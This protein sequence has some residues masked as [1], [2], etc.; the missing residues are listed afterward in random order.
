MTDPTPADDAFLAILRARLGDA[1]VLT[2][3]ADMAP[4]L[5]EARGLYRGSARAVVRPADAGEVA[6]AVRVCAEA[7]VPIVPQGGNTGLVGG[8]VPHGGIVLSLA[9]LA[10]IR[11]LDR[12]GATLTVE[13]G[14]I[15]ADVQRAADEAGMLF[16]LSLAAEGSCRIG[17]NLATN[18]GG[19]GV[20][21]YGNARDLVLGLEVV[22]ADGR[23]WNGLKGLRKN[24]A[25]YD[26][27]HL[28]LGSEGTLGIITAAVLKLFPKPLSR[29]VGFVGLASPRAALRLLEGL[30]RAAGPSLTAFEVMPR[31]GLEIVLAHM[32]GSV[33]P[34]ADAHDTYALVEFSSPRPDAAA[35]AE[36]E[37]ALAAAIEDGTVEDAAI[38]ASEAQNA[39]LWALRENLSDAQRYEGGSIKHDVSVPLARLADFLEQAEAA[40]LEAMPGL[41]PCAFGHFGDGNIHFNLSQPVGMDRAEFLAAWARFNRI[42]H[43]IVQRLDGSIAAEH[44]IGLIKRDELQHY[45]DPVGLDLMRRLK[46]A[47]DPQDLLNPGKVVALSD[48]PPPAL[49]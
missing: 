13:A 17:G 1:H 11:A 35:G 8:G 12:V 38:G 5:E 49:P 16:P 20:L 45:G 22:L 26:L 18:A 2:E 28:F 46:A 36:L 23:V 7:R 25:G 19:T 39:A 4:H 42:V 15:L 14:A 43:D 48:K 10:R 29:A 31:F 3:P 21:A 33:R 47:L 44:G 30:R 27:K 24:N 40:C 32:P 6:F 34:L 37:A 9:R 41:R